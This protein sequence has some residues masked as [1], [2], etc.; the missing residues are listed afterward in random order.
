MPLSGKEIA[1]ALLD[2]LGGRHN[3]TELIL[4]STRLR[5]VLKNA[6]LVKEDNIMRL[7]GITGIIEAD[8]LYFIVPE[9][10]LSLRLY[11]ELADAVGQ[12]SAPVE[13]KSLLR[14]LKDALRR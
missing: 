2:N 8:N 9:P 6:S 5:F 1:Q 12:T 11:N 14:R 10:G 7:N 13:K 4:C 3:V